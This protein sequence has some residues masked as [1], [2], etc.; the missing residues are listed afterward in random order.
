VSD[1]MLLALLVGLFVVSH[2]LLSHP[3]RAPL[4]VAVGADE[5]GEFLR[6]S[7]EFAVHA[8][9]CGVEVQHMQVPHTHHISVVLDALASPGHALNRAACDLLA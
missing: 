5:T 6:Q 7:A 2:E 3:L 1:L 9:R 4:V 8:R